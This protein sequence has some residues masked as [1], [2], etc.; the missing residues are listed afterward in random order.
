MKSRLVSATHLIGTGKRSIYLFILAALLI[1]LPSCCK[2]PEGNYSAGFGLRTEYFTNEYCTTNDHLTF[3]IYE[4]GSSILISEGNSIISNS[5]GRCGEKEMDH[6][7]YKFDGAAVKME[8]TSSGMVEFSMC[9]DV[10]DA[11][12]SLHFE[13][14][15]GKVILDGTVNCINQGMMLTSI[16][17]PRK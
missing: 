13:I 14:I 15:D 9:N 3:R 6:A 8:S 16:Q 17:I 12:G 4:D 5:L 10:F 11:Q 7:R 1:M 2:W